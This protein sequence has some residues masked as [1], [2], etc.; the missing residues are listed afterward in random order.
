VSWRKAGFWSAAYLV[1]FGAFAGIAS[2]G[3]RG[4]SLTASLTFVECAALAAAVPL[5]AV[6]RDPRRFGVLGFLWR[7]A[8]IVLGAI[9]ISSAVMLV[10]RAALAAEAVG[11]ALIAQGVIFA[12][13]LLLASVFAVV[14]CSGSGLLFAQLVAIFVACALLGTVFYADPIIEAQRSSEARGTVIH[15]ALAVNPVTAISGSLLHFDLMRRTVMYGRISVIGQ[16]YPFDYPDWW[17]VLA[18]YAGVSVVLLSGA[19]LLRRYRALKL[20][21]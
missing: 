21:G 2:L 15:A 13:C 19:A 10:A 17:T 8:A 4:E 9:V 20:T 11:G 3:C 12:F 7:I 16:W 5:F 6:R 18:G 14:R 1:A